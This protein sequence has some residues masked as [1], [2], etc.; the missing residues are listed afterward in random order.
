MPFKVFFKDFDRR[1]R[2]ATLQN[3][4]LHRTPNFAEH[5]LMN[6]SKAETEVLEITLANIAS[7]PWISLNIF[8]IFCL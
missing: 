6:Y 5:P 7:E 2:T 4:F 3:S 1:W 8:E